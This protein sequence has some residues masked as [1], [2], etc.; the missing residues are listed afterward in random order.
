LSIDNLVRFL[1]NRGQRSL[2]WCL[3]I[4]FEK[5]LECN[6]HILVYIRLWNTLPLNITESSSLN[7]LIKNRIKHFYRSHRGR[8]H[9]VVGFTTTCTISAYHHLSCE[10]KPWSWRGVLNTTLDKVCQWIASRWFSPAS[11][12]NKTDCHDITEIVLKVALNTIKPNQTK[13][14][15]YYC[16]SI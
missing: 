13:S 2:L 12:T 14:C 1:I 15:I 6:T 3:Q 7:I 11:F 9:L 4:Q 10:F 8:D 16:T 5:Q